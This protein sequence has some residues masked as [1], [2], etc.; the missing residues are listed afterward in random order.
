MDEPDSRRH[1][2]GSAAAEPGQPGQLDDPTA[3]EL[4]E[5]DGLP[6]YLTLAETAELFRISRR[7]VSKLIER[8]ELVCR[9]VGHRVLVPRTSIH[10]WLLRQLEDET[11]VPRFEP[12]EIERWLLDGGFARLEHG[13][14][15]PT[16][17][18]LELGGGIN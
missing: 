4:A 16:E 3:L 7:T 8:G 18:G 2:I 17:V 11:D 1:V 10:F 13:M 14:L 6:L 5:I 15:V 9:H 12:D